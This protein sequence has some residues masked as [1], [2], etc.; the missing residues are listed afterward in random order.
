MSLGLRPPRVT[1]RLSTFGAAC[2]L[3]SQLLGESAVGAPVLSGDSTAPS[4]F[5]RRPRI[6]RRHDFVARTATMMTL[7]VGANG[8]LISGEAAERPAELPTAPDS[9]RAKNSEGSQFLVAVAAQQRE[10]L[11][12]GVVPDVVSA[13]SLAQIVSNKGVDCGSATE[14]SNASVHGREALHGAVAPPQLAVAAPSARPSTSIRGWPTESVLPWR[15]VPSPIKATTSSAKAPLRNPT[16]ASTTQAFSSDGVGSEFM[17]GDSAIVEGD[18]VSS[19]FEG[20]RDFGRS[21]LAAPALVQIESDDDFGHRAAHM[22]GSRRRR[23]KMVA[24]F[25]TDFNGSGYDDIIDMAQGRLFGPFSV[26][27]T[28]RTDE[29]RKWSRIMDFGSGP[30]E[31]NIVISTTA[32][33]G[34][35]A[36]F[37]YTGALARGFVIPRAYEVGKTARYLWSV[38]PGGYMKVWREGALIG[39]YSGTV[40]KKVFRKHFFVA[41][42][43]FPD[44]PLYKGRIQDLYI[45]PTAAQKWGDRDNVGILR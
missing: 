23:F 10:K 39:E 29:H 34:D 27:F 45:W 3:V 19:R 1:M 8:G 16:G 12:S 2:G 28:T 11:G 33:L 24:S 38:S 44:T 14:G 40:P 5:R 9:G 21:A 42:A 13:P 7:G 43:N 32:N 15:A 36:F 18:N 22:K 20:L 25:T 17:H 35:L 31:D 4:T 26:E 41:K 6:L 30:R 37:V